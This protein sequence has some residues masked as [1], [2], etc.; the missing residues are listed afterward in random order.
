M[1]LSCTAWSV[2]QPQFVHSFVG[3]TTQ[4]GLLKVLLPGLVPAMDLVYA[5]RCC[6]LAQLDVAHILSWTFS[7]PVGAA[8]WPAYRSG[9]YI[10]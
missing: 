7:V 2:P 10:Y 8:A 5:G 6:S 4:Q 1:V 9:P 3:A